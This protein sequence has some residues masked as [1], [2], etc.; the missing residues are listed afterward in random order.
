MKVII[1]NHCARRMAQRGISAADI[2]RALRCCFDHYPGDD[3][4]TCHVGY[5]LDSRRQL[6]VWTTPPL[7]PGGDIHKGEIIVKSA[8]WKD[9]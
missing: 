3:G 2:E 6:K 9:R 8:A 7:S 4:G 1:S 5:G